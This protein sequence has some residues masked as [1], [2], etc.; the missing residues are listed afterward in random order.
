MVMAG[1][2]AQSSTWRPS[3]YTIGAA[4][5]EEQVDK[6]FLQLRDSPGFK[7]GSL[8]ILGTVVPGTDNWRQIYANA[9][10]YYC[11]FAAGRND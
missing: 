8:L 11:D 10:E 5:A 1:L 3:R 6:C 7:P 4:V 9:E 2:L